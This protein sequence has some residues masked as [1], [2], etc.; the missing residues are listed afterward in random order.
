VLHW[1]VH[2]GGIGTDGV[3]DPWRVATY[4]ANANPH[5]A[6]L[7]EVDT[8]DQVWAIVDA[9]QSLTGRTWSVS[10]S[11]R[12]NLVLTRLSMDSESRCVYPDGVRYAAQLKVTVNG[13]PVE[14]WST[15]LTES[16]ASARYAEIGSVQACALNW[17]EARII[18][19][20]FNMQAGSWEYGLAAT[21]YQ[22]AWA[23]A[24]A[25]GT[26]I[27]Y[28]GNCD[29][30]T[31]NSRID[32]VFASKGATFL[33]IASAQ[34]IDTRDGDGI[35]PSDHKPLLVTYTVK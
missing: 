14:V 17:P 19:G 6:S 8:D 12:G 16:S 22:D 9:L 35:M 7:N 31:R 34:M 10:F 11:G 18:A 24:S 3:Y 1:N 29:G 23:A 20:D 4:I 33:S 15:H 2:H 21:G 26:S 5:I 13:R 25:N 30:C 27:N 28:S 32:Y